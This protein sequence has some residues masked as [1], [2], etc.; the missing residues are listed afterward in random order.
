MIGPFYILYLAFSDF[1]ISYSLGNLPALFF[2]KISSSFNLT[3]KTPPE[4]GIN[5]REDILFLCFFNSL[6]ERQTAFE[7]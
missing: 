7:R 1:S 4:D 6:S 5:V 2:E 3:S